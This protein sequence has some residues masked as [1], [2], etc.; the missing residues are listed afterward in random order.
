[1]GEHAIPAGVQYFPARVPL[2]P[3]DGH[4]TEEEAQKERMKL[5]KRKGLLLRDERVLAAME[6]TEAPIRMPYVRKKDGSI[7]GDLADY[8]QFVLLKKYLYF[9]LGKMVD[10][11]AS[12]NVE[13]NPYTRGMSHNACTYC[14][15]GAVCH[16]NSVAG[17]RNYQA[18][19]ESEFWESVQ[20]EVNSNGQ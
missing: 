19:S 2:I 1:M 6:N 15:Y 10:E 12:G 11:I 16:K 4:L 17:R 20:E 14:P 7:S 5:W 8:Q 9:K 13:P 18:I 3:A